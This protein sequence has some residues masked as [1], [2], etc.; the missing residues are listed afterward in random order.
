MTRKQKRRLEARN[1][2]YRCSRCKHKLYKQESIAKGLGPKCS[3]KYEH[4]L[5]GL[6]ELAAYEQG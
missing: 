6:R 1:T 5:R 4:E 3:R 2:A